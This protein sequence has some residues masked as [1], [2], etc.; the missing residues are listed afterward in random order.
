M[1]SAARLDTVNT[2][3]KR[4]A[5]SRRYDLVL[6]SV[7]TV[8]RDQ[9][10]KDPQLCLLAIN[11]LRRLQR[12]SEA[13]DLLVAME[14]FVREARDPN[15]LR[16]WQNGYA[17]YLSRQGRTTEAKLLLDECLSSAESAG[18]SRTVVMACNTL[19]LL[20]ITI[21]EVEEATQYWQREI[22]AARRIGD[23][24]SVGYGHY[25]IGVAL[26]EVDKLAEAS[27]HFFLAQEYIV[28][29][30]TE[31]EN[32]LM[33]CERAMLLLALSDPYQ[34]EM[35]IRSTLRRAIAIDNRDLQQVARRVLGAVLLARSN[36]EEARIILEEAAEYWNRKPNLLI[37]EEVNV[38]LAV[39][40]IA[41]RRFDAADRYR[42]RIVEYCEAVGA[43]K[44]LSKAMEKI[45]AATRTV[46]LPPQGVDYAEGVG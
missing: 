35:S 44:R 39:I 18:D 3:A 14:P 5:D 25:N 6:A 33:A 12:S 7:E 24:A 1:Y 21:G 4:Y 40:A 46:M 34:A 32:L 17:S 8:P 15:A 31:E 10:V 36:F 13:A 43:G 20:A 29:T 19:G 37:E 22:V 11:A 38:D 9:L 30:G 45:E 42:Q 23:R 26:R 28:D 27:T 2:D 16:R 41:Q